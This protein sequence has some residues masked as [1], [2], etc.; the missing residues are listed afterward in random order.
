[1]NRPFSVYLDL[2]RFIA[3][4]LVYLY[5][6]N[7]RFLI[8]ARL[9]ASDYGHS[10]VIVF[11]VLSGFVIAFVT[12]TKESELP[13]YA[14]SRIS[15]VFS[16]TVPAIALT[17]VLDAVGRQLM[18]EIYSG[19]PF[20]QFLARIGGSLLLLNE[21]W[22]VSITSFSNVPF[23]SIC[24]EF[25][26]YVAFA[27][28]VFLPRRIGLAAALATGLVM[29]PKL[30]LL[31]PLWWLGVLLHRWHATQHWSPPTSL[32]LAAG[33]VVGVVVFHMWGVSELC[34]DWL[35]GLIGEEAHRELTF[36]KF[37]I[38]DYLLGILV[39]IN[40]ASMR[41]L[42]G[43]HGHGLLRLERPIRMV[44]NYT[45]T[46]YLLHQPLFLFWGAVING[47]PAGPGFWLIVTVLML[48]TVGVV[49]HLTENR[50]Y[51]LRDALYRQ[52]SRLSPSRA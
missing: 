20:D 46:L 11:F 39:F 23:W 41:N 5:H 1:M 52:F 14:A 47:N 29:G 22:F 4:F 40:F 45:F 36:A 37:F 15:R 16:V 17:V 31:A 50:R 27:M 34:S 49:G 19:Y 18:P 25:W 38:G 12:A 44:A 8:E 51:I 3:A 21:V 33:S 10:S 13:A 32:A 7:Q 9:P 24:F 28:I 35:K 2:V 42:L 30:L 26:Y 6:S 43:H 48:L